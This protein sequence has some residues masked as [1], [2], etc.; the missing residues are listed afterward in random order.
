[1]IVVGG[2]AVAGARRARQDA[3]L[4]LL[5]ARRHRGASP[6][7]PAL[8]PGPAR[9]AHRAGQPGALRRPLAQAHARVVRHGGI[10]AVLLLDLDDFKGV[11]DTHGHLVGDQ[12]LVGIARRFELVTRT[13]DTLCRFGGDEF[14]YL[15]E[16]LDSPNEAEE[17]AS[18][19]STRSPSRSP[20]RGAPRAARQHRHRRL[21]RRAPTSRE[22]VQNADVALYEAKRQRAGQLR[23]LH[24]EHAP[25][26][27]QPLHAR[28]GAAQRPRRGEISMHYQP[29]V[30][31]TTGGRRL[32]GADALGPP[33]A[34]LGRPGV[35]IPLAEQSDLILELGAFALLSSRP[36]RRRA[37]PG[38][39]LRACRR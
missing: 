38:P 22:L 13:S 12:L 35:F 34:G 11:N 7:R 1:V 17:V 26:G 6:H 16:G 4:R 36:S 21:G 8:A 5:R 25:A 9:P 32:R 10:G 39:S 33:R 37:S 27:R 30:D 15:A 18:G 19:C 2:V 28:P 24:P 29:I 20:S 14:L 31:L 23:G 3:L